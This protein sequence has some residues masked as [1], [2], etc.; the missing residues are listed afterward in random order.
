[1]TGERKPI[2]CSLA[3]NGFALRHNGSP[4]PCC[5]WKF[6]NV[7]D[8]PALEWWET[9]RYIK[10]VRSKIISDL[11]NGIKHVGCSQ[12]WN[13]ESAGL[14]SLRQR[15][16]Q[17][18]HLK[19]SPKDY[20][21]LDLELNLGTL[22]N[23]RC[24]M[25]GPYASSLWETEYKLNPEKNKPWHYIFEKQ[26]WVDDPKFLIWLTPF[27]KT[28]HRINFSGG[29]PLIIPQFE[30][31]IDQIISLGREKKIQITMNTNLTKLP[32]K[33]LSKLSKFKSVNIM[34]SLEGVGIKNDYLRF[35]S[36]WT[37]IENNIDLINDYSNINIAV[38]HT[39]QH[40]S[41]Y[42]L[43]ELI[44]FCNLKKINNFY[45]NTVQG[46]PQL[47]LSGVP[48]NDIKKF[49]EWAHSSKLPHNLNSMI[50]SIKETKFDIETYNLFRKY[51]AYIDSINGTDWD[52]TFLPSKVL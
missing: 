34:V 46:K 14:K 7:K 21:V 23:L 20:T 35:P 8:V 6:H 16:N 19:N 49:V 45:I 9:D 18:I 51:A 41:I 10:E 38:H 25:C 32:K 43:P 15:I 47:E 29:E 48:E 4:S 24:I 5:Q 50:P 11:E 28:I 42:T 40:S 31:V 1:M 12:C 44:D 3:Y 13:E 37:D 2:H 17:S 33:L 30:L 26:S 39:I 52:A 36:K 27:L 22:C